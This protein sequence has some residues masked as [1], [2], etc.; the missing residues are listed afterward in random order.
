MMKSAPR[1]GSRA[2]AFTLIELLCVITV[3]AILAGLIMPAIQNTT[4]KAYDLK[5]MNNLRQIGVAANSAAND[6][7]NTYPIIEIDPNGNIVSDA[8]DV[9]A[10]PLAQALAPYG[11]TPEILKCPADIRGP[12]D[13]AVMG[14]NSSYMWSPYSEDN[15]SS[16]PSII[17]RRRSN[18]ATATVNGQLVQIPLSRLQLAT[19]WEAVHYASD[20]NAGAGKMIYALYADGHVR[21]SRRASYGAHH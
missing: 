9:P 10:K 2:R 12:N 11:I 4:L 6:N 3:I 15:S 20:A 17:S 21:T 1:L 8:L 13:Y 18:S 16:Q 5:C 7:D 14:Q 19:D